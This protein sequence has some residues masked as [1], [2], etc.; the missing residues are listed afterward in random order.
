[1]NQNLES[2]V[3]GSLEMSRHVSH[4]DEDKREDEGSRTM[5]SRIVDGA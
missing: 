5:P 1:M 3:L 2:T 4:H